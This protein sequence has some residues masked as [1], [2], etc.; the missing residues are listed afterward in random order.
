MIT[1]LTPSS[2]TAVDRPTRRFRLACEIYNAGLER[3]IRAAQSK[4]PIDP[5]GVIRLKVHGHEQVLQVVLRDS[6]WTPADVHKLSSHRT[7]KSPAW[8]PA[9]T[10]TALGV[11][12][13]RRSRHRPEERG[14]FPAGTVLSGRDGF[15]AHGVSGSQLSAARSQRDR[16]RGSQMHPGADRP[17]AANGQL[18]SLPDAIALETDLTT[19]LAYMWSRTDLDRYRWSGLLRPEQALAA[20]QP[21]DD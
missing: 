1:Y 5:Q 4:D 18:A 15:P 10:S 9:T 21:A 14:A 3:L 7:S 2:P 11:P 19:P 16:R 13:D 20:S 6:P 17:G 12:L 8:Q